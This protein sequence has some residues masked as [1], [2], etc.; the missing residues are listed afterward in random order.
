MSRENRPGIL[1]AKVKAL[2]S[3][4][5]ECAEANRTH[6]IITHYFVCLRLDYSYVCKS[7][8]SALN[9]KSFIE[10]IIYLETQTNLTPVVL[11]H[12]N[13]PLAHHAG[14]SKCPRIQK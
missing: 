13:S 6:Y 7:S 10:E 5:C 11:I 4:D 8:L 9:Q 14:I 3:A 1:P 2:C 12:H